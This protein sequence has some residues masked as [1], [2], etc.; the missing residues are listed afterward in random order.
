[1]ESLKTLDELPARGRAMMEAMGAENF[2]RLMKGTG[3][4][5]S[6]TETSLFA[7]NPQMSYVSKE[8]EDTDP[9]FWRPKA[10]K[11]PAENKPKEKTGQ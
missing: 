8:V 7:V 2:G 3:D 1:M 9:D 4:V 10:A 5:F 6:T 11:S